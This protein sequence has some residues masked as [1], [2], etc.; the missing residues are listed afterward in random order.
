[1]PR[2]KIQDHAI[3]SFHRDYP[4]LSYSFSLLSSRSAWSLLLSLQGGFLLR[5]VVYARG[6][7]H[8]QLIN[9]RPKNPPSWGSYLLGV[10]LLCLEP[11]EAGLVTYVKSMYILFLMI[12]IFIRS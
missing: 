3:G 7:N 12:F 2:A 5:L 10:G 9:W 1:M 8:D 11:R 4:A 6:Q